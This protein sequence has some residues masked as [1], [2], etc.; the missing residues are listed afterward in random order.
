MYV[1]TFLLRMTDTMI[2]QN[3]DLSFWDME[4]IQAATERCR[5]TLGTSSPDQKKK[6]VSISTRLEA[7]NL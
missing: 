5:K 7:F 2:S 6:N 1:Y 3:I 4:Y